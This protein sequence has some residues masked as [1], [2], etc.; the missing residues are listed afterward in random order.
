MEATAVHATDSRH[1]PGP[2]PVDRPTAVLRLILAATI[3]ISIVH[4][5]DNTVRYD[6]Y[7]G[8]TSTYIKQ[9][10]IPASW[11]LFTAAGIAGYVYFRR[12]RRARRTRAAVCLALSS[13]GGLVDVGHFTSVSPSDFDAYQLVFIFARLRDRRP[14]PVWVRRLDHP[15]PRA[16]RASRC[17]MPAGPSGSAGMHIN[18]RSRPSGMAAQRRV[19]LR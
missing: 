9:W 12:A 15:D 18:P 2:T 11:V 3:A 10:M 8:G 6:V 4:Y 5:T 1:S 7:T 14:R 13:V 19:R 16:A 17:V